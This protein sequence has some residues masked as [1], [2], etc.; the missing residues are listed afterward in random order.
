[1]IAQVL[2]QVIYRCYD[3]ILL[4]LFKKGRKCR[5]TNEMKEQFSFRFL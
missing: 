4:T 2:Y 1:M 5:G 3:R